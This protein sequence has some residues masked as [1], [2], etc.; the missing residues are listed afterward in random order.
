MNSLSEFSCYFYDKTVAY[1]LEAIIDLLFYTKFL[2]QLC[3]ILPFHI[4]PKADMSNTL[5][6][7]VDY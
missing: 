7:K 6:S 4:F 3:N 2:L 1:F 5:E